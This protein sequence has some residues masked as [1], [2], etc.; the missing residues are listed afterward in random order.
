MTGSYVMLSLVRRFD[1]RGVL[2]QVLVLKIL[3][4]FVDQLKCSFNVS[5][6]STWRRSLGGFSAMS[7]M[8]D[9]L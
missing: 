3:S 5:R 6:A 7:F 1:A 4:T 8:Q 2:I 9:V